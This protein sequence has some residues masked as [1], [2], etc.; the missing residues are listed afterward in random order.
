M[1]DRV[2]RILGAWLLWFVPA[3]LAGLAIARLSVIVQREQARLLVHPLAVGAAVGGACAALM[4][5]AKA[6][7][8]PGSIAAVAFVAIAASAAEHGFFYLDYRAAF[9]ARSPDSFRKLAE[10]LGP[11]SAEGGAANEFWTAATQ[12]KGFWDYMR[13]EAQRGPW[14]WA[15]WLGNPLIAAAAALFV[16]RWFGP[17]APPPAEEHSVSEHSA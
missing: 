15:L 12:P 3:L 14:T 11:T 17:P 16:A 7:R 6:R 2:D 8:S 5:M 10:K 4:H 13:G 9:A 1:R